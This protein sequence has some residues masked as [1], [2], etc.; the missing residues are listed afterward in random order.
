MGETATV[1]DDALDEILSQESINQFR[2]MPWVS[3]TALG[4][5]ADKH[6]KSNAS[7]EQGH[8]KQQKAFELNRQEE[9]EPSAIPKGGEMD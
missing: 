6:F 3:T 5:E 1:F 9:R 2:I 4:K 7:S 8:P